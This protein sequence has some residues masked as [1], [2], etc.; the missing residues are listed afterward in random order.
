MGREGGRGMGNEG[1][2]DSEIKFLPPVHK[3]AFRPNEK[4]AAQNAIL[5]VVSSMCT[6]FDLLSLFE[7]AGAVK[8]GCFIIGSKC[9]HFTTVS[10]VKVHSLDQDRLAEIQY[11]ARCTIKDGDLETSHVWLAAV[12]FFPVH[13][14]KVWYGSPTEVWGGI[15]DTDV[16]YIPLTEIENRVTFTKCST[17]FGQHIGI[18]NVIVATPLY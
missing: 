14:C 5:R 12:C 10:V 18:D 4:L 16:H 8:I 6:P 17:N 11:F 2:R 3:C 15:T 7:K 1:G 13:Q 9:S